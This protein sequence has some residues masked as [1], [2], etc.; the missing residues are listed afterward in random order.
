MQWTGRDG[1]REGRGGEIVNL[2]V[3]IGYRECGLGSVSGS[4]SSDVSE[5]GLVWTWA[6]L[7]HC[8]F[9][10]VDLVQGAHGVR[11]AVRHCLG[12]QGS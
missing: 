10:R 2:L 7:M 8:V 3:I 9:P 4:A 12:K 5:G 1:R 6:T 11:E